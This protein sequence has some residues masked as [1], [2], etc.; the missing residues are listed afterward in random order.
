VV[1][2]QVVLLLV[3]GAYMS[4]PVGCFSVVL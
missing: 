1:V 2:F 4:Q 3:L